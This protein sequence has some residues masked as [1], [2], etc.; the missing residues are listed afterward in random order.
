MEINTISDCFKNKNFDINNNVSA[1]ASHYDAFEENCWIFYDYYVI[2]IY[3]GDECFVTH[4]FECIEHVRNW[5]RE[6][7]RALDWLR[8]EHVLKK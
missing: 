7:R 5:S 3:S 8:L 4:E 6:Q 2:F 1:I